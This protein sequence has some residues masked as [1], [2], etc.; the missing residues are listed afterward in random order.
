MIDVEVIDVIAFVIHDPSTTVMIPNAGI[1]NTIKMITTATRE[2]FAESCA[3][4][5]PKKG[6]TEGNDIHLLVVFGKKRLI[7][8]NDH[9]G[10]TFSTNLHEVTLKL[11][12]ILTK[13]LSQQLGNLPLQRRKYAEVNEK[14]AKDPL[15]GTFPCSIQK[16]HTVP[17]LET[18]L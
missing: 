10:E 7:K 14:T 1:V 18:G 12:R 16:L 11:K 17:N 4:S 15:E 9:H 13:E 5:T 6:K 2:A 8:L 3:L